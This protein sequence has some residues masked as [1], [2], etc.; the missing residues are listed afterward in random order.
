MRKLLLAVTFTAMTSLAEAQQLPD[1]RVA[2]LV[3]VGKVRLALFLPGYTKDPVTGLLRGAGTGAVAEALARALAA[4]LGL[5]VLLVEHPAP[6]HIVPC[7]TAGACDLA[8]MG[9]SPGRAAEVGFSLPFM[10][11]DF[12]YL[13]PSGSSIVSVADADQLGVRIA[14]VRDH[15]STLV[16]SRILKQ[17][18]LV[19]A[20]TPD[21]TFDLLRTGYADVMASPR[22]SLLTYSPRLPGSRVLEDR[23]GANRIAMAVPKGEAGRLAYISEFVE[24][25]KASGLVQ[26]AIDGAGLQGYQVV[27]SEKPK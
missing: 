25:A 24:E 13:V 1:R 27:S 17:A 5:E 2:D 4:R 7:L 26:R 15:A 18:H 3:Q 12:T 19:Y 23:Y 16:L 22:Y 21:L 14:A 8:Y 6:P 10:Q 20:E 11:Q 9:F